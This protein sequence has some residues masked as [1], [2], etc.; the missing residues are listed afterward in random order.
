MSEQGKLNRID[1]EKKLIHYVAESQN[2]FNEIHGNKIL[3]SS[4]SRLK[5]LLVNNIV[6][7][8]REKAFQKI[9]Y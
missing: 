4:L 6:G 9:L 3:I 7:I 2:I 8:G 5:N 1:A